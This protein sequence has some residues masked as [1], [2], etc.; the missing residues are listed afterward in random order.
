MFSYSK[1]ILSAEREQSVVISAQSCSEMANSKIFITPQG[2]KSESIVVPGRTYV[3]EFE[4]GF[5][6][7]SNSEIKCQGQDILLDGS[8]QKGIVQHVEY[9]IQ[10]ESE[11]FDLSNNHITARSSAEKLAC[12]SRGPVLG[13]VGA[14]H[15][16]A[17]SPPKSSCQ[18]RVVREV[19]GLIAATY[20]AADEAQLYYDLKRPQTLPFSCGEP[21]V[22]VTNVQDIVLMRTDDNPETKLL[23][24][25]P[26]DVSYS[27]EIR[28]L[29]LFLRYKLDIVEGNKNSLGAQII[30]ETSTKEP[31]EAPPHK[32]GNGLYLFRRRDIAFQYLCKPKTVELRETTLCYTD[33][34]IHSVG[35]VSGPSSKSSLLLVLSLDLSLI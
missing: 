16:Y 21:K 9:V 31:R 32:I 20:F 26:L 34:P 30:C 25:N 8:I 10:V 14:L 13:C 5:Q 19:E 7:A 23:Q 18:Y 6:T 35:S 2:R 28:S 1:P 15:T 29:S 3:M 17:W 27:G 33:A 11:L 4:I 24:I 22:F 12:N